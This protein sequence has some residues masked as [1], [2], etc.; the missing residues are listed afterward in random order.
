MSTVN[1]GKRSRYRIEMLHRPGLRLSE[2]DLAR[3]VANVRTV[4]A[5]CFDEVPDYQCMRGT[6]A[7]L[8]DKV[9]TLAWRADGTLAGFCSAV[10]LPVPGVGEVLHL[11]LTCVSQRDRSSGLTHR[12]TSKLTIRYLLRHRPLS[13]V[14]VTNVACVLSSLANVGRHFD[15]VYPSPEGPETATTTHRRI[16]EAI[17][18]LYRDKI[19][20]RS[21]AELDRDAFVFRGS[22]RGTVFQKDEGDPRYHHRDAASNAFYSSLLSFEDGDEVLQIGSMSLLTG[23]RY[24]RRKRA[25]APAR[26]RR[27]IVPRVPR[28]PTTEIAPTVPLWSAPEAVDRPAPRA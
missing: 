16:A 2:A 7:E 28:V 11:G 12:L 20:I 22:V 10:L 4:A 13:R 15:R 3:L 18:T 6:R 1:H 24:L 23:L 8:S 27:A 25:A 14:W 21:D 5:E 26:A 17:D 9:M 19:Y